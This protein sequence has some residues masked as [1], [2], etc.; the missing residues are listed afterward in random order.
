MM[1]GY[2]VRMFAEM[3]DYVSEKE[4]KLLDQEKLQRTQQADKREAKFME[5]YGTDK[6]KWSDDVWE[7][8]EYGD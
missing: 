2:S 1:P 7:E 3:R 5:K 6:A 8:Y 4:L